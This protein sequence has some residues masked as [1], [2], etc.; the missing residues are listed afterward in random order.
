MWIAGLT[1]K[2]S[3]LEFLFNLEAN[4]TNTGITA[5]SDYVMEVLRIEKVV[6]WQHSSSVAN[7]YIFHHLR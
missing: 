7:T 1:Q 3:S 5:P 2:Q 4:Y 6:L